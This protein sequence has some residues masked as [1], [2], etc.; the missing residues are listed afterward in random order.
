MFLFKPN[1]KKMRETH[2]IAGLL[3][4]LENHNPGKR[5]TQ[6]RIEAIN[7]LSEF[8]HRKVIQ[9]LITILD[10]DAEVLKV[11]IAA[12]QAIKRMIYAGGYSTYSQTVEWWEQNKDDPKLIER[13]RS[14]VRFEE[15]ANAKSAAERMHS[16]PQAIEA[17]IHRKSYENST[18]VFPE[19]I[20]WQ[21]KTQPLIDAQIESEKARLEAK[22][23]QEDL[24]WERDDAR[25][26]Q[27]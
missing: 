9:A 12:Q 24:L 13:N 22:W 19:L 20:E 4:L 7:A 11:K 17:L 21:N 8:C 25:L 5:N 23:Q 10:D 27:R 18:Y 16:P 15:L 6:V 3:K 14:R 1:I 26:N 2:N